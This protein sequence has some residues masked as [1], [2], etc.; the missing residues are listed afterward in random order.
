MRL[1][2]VKIGG[3]L[4]ESPDLLAHTL[5]AFA[6]LEG[7]KLLIHGGGRAATDLAQQLGVE[8]PLIHGRR[9]TSQAM[10]DIALM[11]YGGLMSRQLVAALQQRGL[12]ALGL[13]GADLD[14]IRA[15]KRPVVDIDYGLVGDI[16]RVNAPRLAMLLDQEAVPVLAPLTHDGQGQM[17]NTNA[18]TIAATVAAAMAGAYEVTLIFAFERPGV[19]TD[20]HDDASLLPALNRTQA[21][22]LQ[23]Q[24]SIAGGMLP[25]LHNAWLALEAGAQRVL[26]GQAVDGQFG[27]TELYL[28]HP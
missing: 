6:A 20:P 12:D 28:G 18:D 13:T 3:G 16:S 5:D 26:I 11:V 17:L 2:L 15:H 1:T 21:Q 22:A 4:L 10:L 24:G 8:A 14:L 27:G 7:A 19:L 23:A 25:K 9:V